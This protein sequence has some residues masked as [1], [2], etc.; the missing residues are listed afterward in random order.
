M[1]TITDGAIRLLMRHHW[2]GNVREMENCLERSAIM[3]ANGVIAQDVIELSG[4]SL[5]GAGAAR[6]PLRPGSSWTHPTW[7]SGSGS[8]PR[9]NKLVGCR[10][11]QPGYWA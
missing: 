6:S 8:L 1:L 2:P 10:P 9:W 11:R 7:T 3:S 5:R 4:L